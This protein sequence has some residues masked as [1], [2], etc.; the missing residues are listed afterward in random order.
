[1]PV[2]VRCPSCGALWRL[3]ADASARLRCSEC[4]AS[5]EAARAEAVEL[6]DAQY[7]ALMQKVE[8]AHSGAVEPP[9]AP[10]PTPKAAPSIEE[11]TPEKEDMP[12]AASRSAG[13][14][15]IALAGL[16]ALLAV[17]ASV[18]NGPLLAGAPWLRPAYEKYCGLVPCPGF[19][20]SQAQAFSMR[21]E[22]SDMNETSVTVSL[23]IENR[24]EHPQSLPL[25]EIHLLD[26]AG[27][28][29]AQRLLEPAELGFA[30]T[31]YLSPQGMAK[32]RADVPIPEGL[33][34]T[35][36]SAKAVAPL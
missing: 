7:D 20:W 25:I 1:M 29:L 32:V 3:P 12:A 21:A 27:D 10:T 33:P 11:K 18:C 15:L 28:T 31:D 26:A 14:I 17:G 35:S 9:A 5:F 22:V 24:S 13:T 6:S 34:V 36:A 8:P 30:A 4:G 23:A 19:V 2:I 16:V